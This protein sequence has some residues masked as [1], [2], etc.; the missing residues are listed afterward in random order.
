L[1]NGV[2]GAIVVLYKQESIMNEPGLYTLR[3]TYTD[4]DG[5]TIVS[6][7]RTLVDSNYTLAMGIAHHRKEH[8]KR[9]A[10]PIVVSSQFYKTAE[11]IILN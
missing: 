3:F 11:S 7:A 8:E 4:I 5:E 6:Y 2:V 1:T 10:S 9:N